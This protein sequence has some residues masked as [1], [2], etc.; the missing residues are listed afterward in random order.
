MA[1]LGHDEFFFLKHFG[2]NPALFS[3][4]RNKAKIDLAVRG[5]LIDSVKRVVFQADVH[6]VESAQEIADDRLKLVKPDAVDRGDAYRAGEFPTDLTDAYLGFL[7]LPENIFR[8]QKKYF[9]AG[10]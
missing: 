5:H 7:V 6:L 9:P 10:R 8:I 3:R 1:G 4:M 2:D